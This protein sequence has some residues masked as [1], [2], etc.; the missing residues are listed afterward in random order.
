VPSQSKTIARITRIVDRAPPV[1]PGAGARLPAV[2]EPI[3]PAVADPAVQNPSGGD[4]AVLD[5]AVRRVVEAAARKGVEL[6]IVVLDATTHTAA[7][8]AR[9]LGVEQAQ[10]V[11][12]LVFVAP[13]DDAGHE[14]I[15]CLVS[16]V[17]RV[18][19]ARLAA[20]VGEPAIRRATAREARDLT[21]FAIGGI[22]PVGHAHALRV[23]MD[24]DLDLHREVW[25]AAG[26]DRA[27]FPVAPSA[28]RALANAVVAP[29]ADAAIPADAPT[30][31]AGPAGPGR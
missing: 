24:P 7:D 18:D 20:V 15:L 11:K 19:V 2:P 21:G 16:G 1:A 3:D 26:I 4:R 5:P 8:A 28:L 30:S 14:P 22:P 27:V 9:A 13:R 25:A 10:I 23:V 29:I 31:A 6:R 12:S 17:N